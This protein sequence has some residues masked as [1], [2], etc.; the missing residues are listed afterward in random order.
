[1]GRY[2]IGGNRLDDQAFEVSS[3]R[4]RDLG[5]KVRENERASLDPDGRS[6]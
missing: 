4:R 6:P 2:F 1:M 5:L 3:L